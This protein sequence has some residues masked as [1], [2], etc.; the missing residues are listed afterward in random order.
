MNTILMYIDNMFLNLPKNAEVKRAKEELAAM[1]EDK[2]NQLMAEGRKE[3]EAVGIVISEFGNLEELAAE[4]GLEHVMNQYVSVEKK[5]RMVTRQESEEYMEL[6][7]KT[8]K[9]VAF[10]VMLCIY[11]PLMLFIVGGISETRPISDVEMVA[12]GLIPLFILIGSAVAIFIFNGVKLEKFDYL[13]KEEF[14]IDPSLN[15]YLAEIEELEKMKST[16]KVIIGVIMCFFAVI[17]LLLVGSI[18]SSDMANTAALCLMLLIIGVA[19]RLIIVGGNKM[20]SIKLLRE[21]YKNHY[22][23]VGKKEKKDVKVLDV[24]AGIYWPVAT[25]IYLVWSFTTMDWGFTWIVWPVAGIIFG[26]I[27]ATCNALFGDARG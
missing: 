13:K 8:T 23:Y 27:A 20:E 18:D 11:S 7:Y 3:N 5:V 25:V 9:W 14:R 24:I 17:P 4:L 6:S 12:F 16:V 15:S 10:G 21:G 22:V 1:M 19:V 26:G 2:Y